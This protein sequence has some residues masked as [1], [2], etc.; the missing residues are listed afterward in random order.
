MVLGATQNE[1]TPVI[2]TPVPMYLGERALFA[3]EARP[4]VQAREAIPSYSTAGD[5]LSLPLLA[6]TNGVISS[7]ERFLRAEKR[8]PVR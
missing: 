8:S 7:R 1:K 5:C 3:S 4:G 2:A 6:E